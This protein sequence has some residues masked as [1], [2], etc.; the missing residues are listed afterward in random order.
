M[1]DTNRMYALVVSE[2]IFLIKEIIVK[3]IDVLLSDEQGQQKTH[4]EQQNNS[5]NNNNNS[6]KTKTKQ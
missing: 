6:N 4:K 2:N 1:Q 5:K 3:M